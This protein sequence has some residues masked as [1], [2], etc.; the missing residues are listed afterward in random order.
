MTA[1]HQALAQLADLPPARQLAAAGRRLRGAAEPLLR[2]LPVGSE[3]APHAGRL[4]GRLLEVLCERALGGARGAVFTPEAEARVLAAFGLAEAAARRGVA[5]PA[6]LAELLG[7]AA[8]SAGLRA[9]LDGLAVLDPCCGAGA[10]LAAAQLL[11]A[12]VGARLRLLGLDVAPLAVQAARARLGL[13]GAAARIGTADALATPWPAA[14]LLVANPPF[15]RHEALPAPQKEVACRRSG[16]SRQADLAAHL[17]ALALRHA[18]VAALVLPRGLT[19]ARSAEPLLAEA[20]ARG[21]FALWLTARAA[22]SFAASVDTSLAVWVEG[23]RARPPAEAQVAIGALRADELCALASGCSSPRLRLRAPP[24]P[25]PRGAG[26]VGDLCEVRFGMKS[27]CNAF[28]HLLPLGQGRYRSPLA[29]E[30]ALAPAEVAPVLRSLK[31]AAA[32]LLLSPAQVIFRPLAPGPGGQAYVRRGEALGVH[33]RATCAGRS[34]WW[35]VAR[36][37]V[38]APVLYPAKI[39]ARAFAVWNAAGLWEDKKWHALF[40]RGLPPELLAAVLCATPVRLAVDAGA[41]QLTGAQAIADVDCRVL[42]AAACPAAGAL[43]SVAREIAGAFEALARD[44]VTTDLGAMLDR[45]AQRALDA[46]VG[47]AMGL[48]ARALSGQRRALLDRLA[49]RLAKAAHIRQ[50]V[51]SRG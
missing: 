6:A 16:L 5:A 13:L 44:P 21:G 40:P 9:A 19:T 28:F 14:D 47:R 33:R 4:D 46:A 1:L 31:E 38:P 11:A 50:R 23:A 20:R 18:P 36:G 15:L 8:P 43:R 41:R 17:A 30:V 37:R 26:S 32:P 48:G 34:P 25:A 35:L 42:A 24:A 22:G 45:P 10:L 49:A 2:H 7:E 29:G 51:A 39:G 27:G 12:R 3:A